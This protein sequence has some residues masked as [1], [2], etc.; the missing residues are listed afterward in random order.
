MSEEPLDETCP[1]CGETPI[2]EGEESE[3][4]ECLPWDGEEKS[5]ATGG[6]I[7]APG[8][9]VGDFIKTVVKAPKSGAVIAV[10]IDEDIYSTVIATY[11]ERGVVM[12]EPDS[13]NLFT[14]KEWKDKHGTDGLALWAI[15]YLYLENAG[16]GVQPKRP[17]G[18]KFGVEAKPIEGAGQLR[19]GSKNG[20]KPV[21][22]GKY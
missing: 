6:Q 21:K 8:M 9:V 3:W 10:L 7:R 19:M 5:L 14:R 2:E 11:G 1:D 22:L 16:P 20:A 4:L 18:T 15:R 17:K 13:G 12:A